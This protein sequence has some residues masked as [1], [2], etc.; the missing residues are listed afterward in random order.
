VTLYGRRRPEQTPISAA[1]GP[2]LA[3]DPGAA[4]DPDDDSTGGRTEET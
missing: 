3:P 1:A 2:A 4:P